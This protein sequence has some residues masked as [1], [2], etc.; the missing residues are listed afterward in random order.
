MKL[1]MLKV[2][3]GDIVAGK[4]TWKLKNILRK[5]NETSIVK[6]C[7]RNDMTRKTLLGLT[8]CT[9]GSEV[10]LPVKLLKGVEDSL[11]KG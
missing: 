8:A 10:H 2:F 3:L 6:F 9:E 1:L 5:F 7:Y 4:A 11:L